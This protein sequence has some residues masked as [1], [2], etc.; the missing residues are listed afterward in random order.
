MSCLSLARKLQRPWCDGL[1]H[2]SV[3][4]L[5]RCPPQ[6]GLLYST[7]APSERRRA[8]WVAAEGGPLVGGH[9]V[10]WTRNA[11]EPSESELAAWQGGLR[12]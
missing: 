5:T 4:T 6:A 11:F 2:G 1:L 12:V 7:G 3:H 8:G 9:V 10:R